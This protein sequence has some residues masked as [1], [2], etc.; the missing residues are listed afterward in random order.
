MSYIIDYGDGV[1]ESLSGYD[2]PD[3][4][5]AIAGEYTVTLTETVS[6]KSYSL[7]VVVQQ[8]TVVHGRASLRRYPTGRSWRGELPKALCDAI[9]RELE[10]T[11]LA[12]RQLSKVETILFSPENMENWEYIL[13]LSGVGTI[14][15]R[16]A[17]ILSKMGNDSQVT[18]DTLG[19]LSG[20]YIQK[21]LR[22]AGFDVY[23][24]SNGSGNNILQKTTTLGDGANFGGPYGTPIG[25]IAYNPPFSRFSEIGNGIPDNPTDFSGELC[26]NFIDSEKDSA[27]SARYT[28]DSRRWRYLFFICGAVFGENAEVQLIRKEEFRQL[29]LQLKAMGDWAMLLVDYI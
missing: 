19:S 9:G 23:V 22:D 25:G 10:E 2:I 5:Y 1:I 6:G 11:K 4:I 26:V 29:V 27:Y 8:E 28:N 14:E 12:L 13:G 7:A 16:K 15:E 17:A 3:H 21:C 18:Y 20:Q 24:F